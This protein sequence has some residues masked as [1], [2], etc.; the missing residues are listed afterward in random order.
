[1]GVSDRLLETVSNRFYAYQRI[2][3]GHRIIEFLPNGSIGMGRAGRESAWTLENNRLFVIGSDG[4]LT[5][6]LD[7]DDGGWVGKWKGWD[8]SG[9]LLKPFPQDV[10]VGGYN[11]LGNIQTISIG[12]NPSGLSFKG[13]EM[14]A[15]RYDPE[16]SGGN[17]KVFVNNKFV[18]NNAED[19][20]LFIHNSRLHVAYVHNPDGIMGHVIQRYALLTDDLKVERIY[21]PEYG[22]APEKNWLFFECDSRLYAVYAVSPHTV[23]EIDG[24][25]VKQ[26]YKSSDFSNL[27]S[28]G[29]LH[30][31]ANPV[32]TGD[33][34]YALAHSSI[35][36]CVY[37]NCIYTFEARPP[38]KQI[39]ITP[40]IMVGSLQCGILFGSGL[41]YDEQSDK[42]MLYYGVGDNAS[43]RGELANNSLQPLL[44]RWD[45]YGR[46]DEIANAT[47]VKDKI[48]PQGF[49]PDNIDLPDVDRI[50]DFGCG[51]GRNHPMLSKHAS[52][53]DGFD[54][55]EMIRR[56]NDSKYC[57]LLYNWDELMKRRYDL[58]YVSN[59]FQHLRRDWIRR[60]VGDLGRITSQLVVFTN[61][62]CIGGEFL[63]DDTE[64]K[65][66]IEGSGFKLRSKNPSKMKE[67]YLYHFDLQRGT[68]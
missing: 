20:R 50:L 22:A 27:W 15:Y 63:R 58:V 60:Y 35:S 68:L 48:M 59:V 8:R 2:G 57:E 6:D 36:N 17:S 39:D 28:Y 19:P 49:Y 34:F 12:Y 1:M 61:S 10:I 30:G 3:I 4:A 42:W 41:R 29:K 11:R 14:I 44:S 56:F 46:W 33:R 24:N 13:E 9:V 32:L 37:H 53:V 5:M 54:I 64:L 67:H 52:Q 40:P 55:P 31:G 65:D 26:V 45:S 43:Q 23:I 21:Q 62:V 38:F 51:L 18:L 66:V 47:D 7:Y 25:E 16:R